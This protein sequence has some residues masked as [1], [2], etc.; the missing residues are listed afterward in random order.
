MAVGTNSNNGASSGQSRTSSGQSSTAIR[1]LTCINTTLAVASNAGHDITPKTSNTYA[2]PGT[3]NTEIM[4][5]P[6]HKG[7]SRCSRIFGPKIFIY[8]LLMEGKYLD[9]M[10]QFM[11]EMGP[12]AYGRI[13]GVPNSQVLNAIT[14]VPP[15]DGTVESEICDSSNADMDNT[16]FIVFDNEEGKD[17]YEEE[18]KQVDN[19]VENN[20]MG[21][22]WMWNNWK[23]HGTE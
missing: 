14:A 15:N 16:T 17:E 18:M 10:Q 22:E 19:D 20:I 4:T 21:D 8:N 1:K 13:V 23:E 11:E 3:D 5:L 9:T 12:F 7:Y 6:Q 2:P